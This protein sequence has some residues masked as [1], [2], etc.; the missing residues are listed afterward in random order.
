[1]A[2]GPFLGGKRICLG[3]TFV[4][5]MSKIVG[6]T[7][8]GHFDYEFVDRNFMNEKPLNNL[9]VIKEPAIMIRLKHNEI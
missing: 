6:P 8:I 4:E 7:I 5:T 2:F 1:M 9:Y 3:K